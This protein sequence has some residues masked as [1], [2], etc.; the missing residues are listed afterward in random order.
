MG[1][2]TLM[3]TASLKDSDGNSVGGLEGNTTILFRTC[4]ANF[5][6]LSIVNNGAFTHPHLNLNNV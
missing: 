6:D 4:W 5:S 3:V 2:T 1:V